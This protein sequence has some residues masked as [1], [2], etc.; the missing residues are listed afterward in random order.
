MYNQYSRFFPAM[1]RKMGKD[2]EFL[3]FFLFLDRSLDCII[4]SAE[5]PSWYL[6]ST[7]AADVVLSFEV[8]IGLMKGVIF[9]EFLASIEQKLDLLIKREDVPPRNGT[10]VKFSPARS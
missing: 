5:R 1:K 6:N 2:G 7:V 4:Y 10:H 9:T 8:E 3:V